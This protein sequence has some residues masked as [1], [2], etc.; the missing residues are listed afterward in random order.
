[1]TNNDMQLNPS[2][3]RWILISVAF[4]S[5]IVALDTYIVNVSLPAIA[6]YF[7]LSTG[8]VVYVMVAYLLVIASTLL[9]FG[10]LG[11]RFGFKKFFILGF[12][13]FTAGSLSCGLSPSVEILIA[14]RCL[15]GIGGAMLY[16]IGTALIP[17]HLPEHRRG[18]AFGVTSTTAG[19]GM[20]LG[21]PIGG[22]IT[23][24]LSWQWIFLINVPIGIAAIFIAL[25]VIPSDNIMPGIEQ[26]KQR[27]DFLGAILSFFGLLALV[28]AINQGQEIGWTS[29]LIIS[30]FITAAILLSAFFIWERRCRDPIL[31]LALFKIKVFR[32]AILA[33]FAAFALYAGSNFLTPFYLVYTRGLSMSQAGLIIMIYSVVYMILSPFMGRFSDKINPT[34]LA[35][36][37]IGSAMLACTF[38]A[39]TLQSAGLFP[40]VIFFIWLAVSYSAFMSP[41]NNR[42]MSVA[43]IEKQGMASGVYRT[44][45]MLGMVIGVSLLETIF[46]LHLPKNA[47]D[48]SLNAVPQSTL[49]NGFHS[50]YLAGAAICAIGLILSLLALTKNPK[51]L[52]QV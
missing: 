47:L 22:F 24:F 37:G 23:Q 30:L 52:E 33:G 9:L 25:R 49:L 41:N 46:S 14:S 36:A 6:L 1:M 3:Q 39:L 42:L 34:L 15:Q 32:Y 21:S 17:K 19:L 20:A 13:L 43:P 29:V 16:A 18:L 28:Y 10:K 44:V 4:T 7:K 12:C 11:D 31:H 50:A 35:S 38:F 26:K 40:I 48:T 5:F 2:R 8:D 51:K 27:F 45:Q